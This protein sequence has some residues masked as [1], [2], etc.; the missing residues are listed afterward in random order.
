MSLPGQPKAFVTE[1]EV[2]SQDEYGEE[3]RRTER[4]VTEHAGRARRPGI[5]NVSRPGA[6]RTLTCPV[7]LRH[8]D[9]GEPTSPRLSALGQ[10]GARA[11]NRLSPASGRGRSIY[12]YRPRGRVSPTRVIMRKC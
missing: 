4:R 2:G 3:V 8:V 9:F 11:S 5:V 7:S 12:D 1:G 10:F 6:V